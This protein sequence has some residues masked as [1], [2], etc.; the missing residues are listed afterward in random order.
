MKTMMDKLRLIA[1]FAGFASLAIIFVPV[2]GETGKVDT[3]EIIPVAV[4]KS[5]VPSLVTL[6][7][8]S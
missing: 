4:E 5:D 3:L 2:S 8:K 1:V 7:G 6:V